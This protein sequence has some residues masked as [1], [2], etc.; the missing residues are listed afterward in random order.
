MKA[1]VSLGAKKKKKKGI[2]PKFVLN[3]EP[4]N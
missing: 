3:F 1:R 4:A 2:F